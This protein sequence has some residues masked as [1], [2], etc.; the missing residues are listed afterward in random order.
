[1][2]TPTSISIH[3][4]FSGERKELDSIETAFR[5]IKLELGINK[6]ELY[7]KA[8]LWILTNEK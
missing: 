7:K 2:S 1:M 5:W 3:I 6:T 4:A 8:L